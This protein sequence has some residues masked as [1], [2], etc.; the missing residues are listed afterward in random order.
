MQSFRVAKNKPRKSSKPAKSKSE[1][2]NELA[3]AI[4]SLEDNKAMVSCTKC[5]EENV[6]CYYDREQSMSCAECIRHQ[7][8]CD[9][10][11]ALEEVRKVGVQKKEMQTKAREERRRVA[12]LR[13]VMLEAQRQ[14]AKAQAELAEAESADIDLQ[15][16]LA[17][18]EE[19]S[20]RMLRREM[21]VLGVMGSLDSERE[22]VLAEPEFVWEGA[23]A[24]ASVDWDDVWLGLP[25]GDLVAV[26]ESG[27][28]GSGGGTQTGA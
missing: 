24:S 8:K 12:R 3:D 5:V 6:V 16:E 11:F 19:T 17:E 4:E 15:D 7:R 27:R 9:G 18:L 20:N 10:T 1:G 22:V 2:R 21:Q 25:S 13:K 14:Y 23:P 28:P 26:G